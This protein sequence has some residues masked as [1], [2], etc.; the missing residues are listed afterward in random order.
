MKIIAKIYSFRY[1]LKN[2]SNK[3]KNRPTDSE[4]QT[5]N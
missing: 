4:S 1:K 2:L 5:N 3:F